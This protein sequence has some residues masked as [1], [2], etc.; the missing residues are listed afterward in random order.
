MQFDY[1]VFSPLFQVA[2]LA[3]FSVGLWTVIGKH[4]YVSLLSTITYPMAAYVLLAA[5]T[6]ATIA[7]VLGYCGLWRENR[8]M[9][10]CVSIR[11]S[12]K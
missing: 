12:L 2:G 8:S 5:G 10:L 3:V 11:R 4:Q 7:S 1:N 6:L 9:L